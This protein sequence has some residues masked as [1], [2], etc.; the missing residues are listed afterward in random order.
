MR[1]PTWLRAVAVTVVDAV[2]PPR[3]LGCGGIVEAPGRLCMACWT[4]IRF[5][6]PPCCAVCGEPFPYLQE[7]NALCLSC[8]AEPPIYDRARAVFVYDE[9][10]RKLILSF[11]HGDRTDAAPAYAA[12]MRRAGADL[13]AHADVIAPVPLHRWRLLRRRYNQAALLA[14]EIS[15]LSGKPVTPDLLTRQRATPSL[16]QLGRLARR[17]TLRGAFALEETVEGRRIL[18]IDDVLTSGAT[19]NECA[20]LL[21]RAG[22][23]GVDVLTLARVTLE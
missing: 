21:K 3:C 8:V 20:R 9:E 19:V 14:L 1:P 16:G 7:G 23:A 17:R 6:G 5:L 4:P 10:T 12:W 2:L 11:K 15:R 22:A 18:L 13:I